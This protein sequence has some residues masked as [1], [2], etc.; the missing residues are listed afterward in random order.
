MDNNN[1]EYIPLF[2]IP[3]LKVNLPNS[4]SSLI[5]YFDSLPLKE[6]DNQELH[7]GQQS[8]DT[9]ILESS[10]CKELKSF[11]LNSI[12]FFTKTY[13][14]WDPNLNFKLTQSWVTIKN[15]GESHNSHIHSNSQI[16][17]VLYYGKI[18]SNT[19]GITFTDINSIAQPK[20]FKITEPFANSQSEYENYNQTFPAIPG[21]MYLFPSYLA[22]SVPTNT[23]SIPR[24]SISFNSITEGGF[25]SIDGLTRLK[26]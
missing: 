10:E 8:Q 11:I 15:P 23:T 26:I 1:F 9:Y 5:P 4:L 22:H 25:G 14:K 2:P 3:L 21:V 13:L 18:T 6:R 20:S 17:G 24:K 16:S 12:S 19:P 7:Y